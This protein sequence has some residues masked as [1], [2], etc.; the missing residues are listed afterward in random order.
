MAEK[1]AEDRHED[2]LGSKDSNAFNTTGAE[3]TFIDAGSL[4]YQRGRNL[5]EILVDMELDLK[6]GE[7]STLEGMILKSDKNFPIKL[8]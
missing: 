7:Q 8:I 5:D 3:Y 1:I 4:V 2:I 6:Y